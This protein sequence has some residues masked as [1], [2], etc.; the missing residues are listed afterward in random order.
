MKKA[1]I[2]LGCPE[3]PSQTPLAIYAAYKLDK[4]GFEVT[5]AST[6]SAM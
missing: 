5:L 2:L 3:S 4:M 6:P 1:L